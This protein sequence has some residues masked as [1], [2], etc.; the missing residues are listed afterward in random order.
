MLN[1]NPNI[2]NPYIDIANTMHAVVTPP[3]IVPTSDTMRP[4]Y[5][6]P[7]D[8]YLYGVTLYSL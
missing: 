7:P 6:I 4:A 8:A 3:K 1:N 2:A 5:S